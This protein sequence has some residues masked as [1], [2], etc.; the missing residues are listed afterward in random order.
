MFKREN[1]EIYRQQG[2]SKADTTIFQVAET[3]GIHAVRDLMKYLTD[4]KDFSIEN[5]AEFI[6]DFINNISAFFIILFCY[7]FQAGC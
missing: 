5:Q 7:I 2:D 3:G 1:L 4:F 6:Q